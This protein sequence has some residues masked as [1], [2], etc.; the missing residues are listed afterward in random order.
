MVLTTT[1]LDHMVDGSGMNGTV[2]GAPAHVCVKTDAMTRV[3][4]YQQLVDPRITAELA[5][6]SFVEGRVWLRPAT[7][8]IATT[9]PGHLAWSPPT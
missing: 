2:L 5:A 9:T 1:T 6:S 8:V 3:A 4:G 7:A